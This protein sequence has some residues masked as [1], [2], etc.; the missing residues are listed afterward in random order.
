MVSPALPSS[1]ILLF[2]MASAE[3]TSCHLELS[4]KAGI[5]FSFF[6]SV[7][8]FKNCVIA[9]SSSQMNS[10][11]AGSLQRAAEGEKKG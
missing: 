3:I 5:F 4:H 11:E 10:G 2:F 1:H 9:L 8:L 7:M 6:F